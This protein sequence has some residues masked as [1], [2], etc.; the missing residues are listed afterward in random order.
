MTI[1]L[2]SYEQIPNVGLYLEQVTKFINEYLTLVGCAPITGSMVSNYVKTGI[3]PNPVKKQYDRGHIALLMMVAV[4][5][6]VLSLEQTQFL[7]RQAKAEP[8]AVYESFC[9]A[10]TEALRAVFNGEAVTLVGQSLLADT[11][12][13]VA[14]RLYLEKRF[15]AWEQDRE[16]T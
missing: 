13:A 9:T 12:A 4:C 7:L 1:S 15:C 14:H 2:P 10:L 16:N 6:T 5:K 3:V 11:L 8:Q